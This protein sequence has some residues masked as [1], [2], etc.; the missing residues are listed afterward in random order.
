[1]QKVSC[2]TIPGNPMLASIRV[3]G[4]EVDRV[5]TLYSYLKNNVKLSEHK[6]C[7][8]FCC[9]VPCV[10]DVYEA[11]HALMMNVFWRL[12]DWKG[13]PSNKADQIWFRTALLRILS[14]VPNP[15]PGLE[16]RWKSV[17][18]GELFLDLQKIS[19]HW[20]FFDLKGSLLKRCMRRVQRFLEKTAPQRTTTKILRSVFDIYC[21]REDIFSITKQS[22]EN[23]ALRKWKK[24]SFS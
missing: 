24:K 17:D 13:P 2:E 3:D 6:Q 9:W 10:F 11:N 4:I 22:L 14:F 23:H 15:P 1:M 21:T 18:I 16:E 12:Q 5:P 20:H 8:R 7:Q 19:L